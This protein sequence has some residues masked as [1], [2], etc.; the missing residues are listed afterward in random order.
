MQGTLREPGVARAEDLEEW[1][2]DIQLRLEHGGD[3]DLG[4]HPEALFGE[5]GSDSDLRIFG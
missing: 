3:V 2:I 4:E 1:A 5:R